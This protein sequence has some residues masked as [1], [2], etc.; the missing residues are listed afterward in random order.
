MQMFQ[1][2]NRTNGSQQRSSHIP[3]RIT[4]LAILGSLALAALSFA[5]LNNNVPHARA[6][7]WTQIWSD[8]FNGAAGTGLNNSNWLYDLGT[9]Y[10]GGAG[11]WGTGEVE[12]ETN[13][14][15]NVYQDGSGHLAIKPIRDANGNWTSGRVETQRT[16]FAAPAGGMIAFEASLQMPNVTGA[17]AQGY[18]PAFWMLGDSF[19]GNYTNWPMAGE[20]DGMENVNGTNMEYGTLHCGYMPG[21]PCNE[22]NGLGGHQPCA[23]TTCQAAFHTYRVEI[24][25]STSPEQIRWYLDGNQFWQVSANS[26]D[27]TTWTNAVDHGFFVILNVAMGGSW[28]GN[29]SGATASGVPMLIDYVRVFTSGGSGSTPTPV[30]SSTPGST[31]TPTPTPISNCPSGS[32]IQGADSTGAST[33][34][35]WFKPCDWTAGYVIIHY[36]PAG[37]GQQNVYM[38]YNAGTGHWEYPI[39]GLYTGQNLQ[40]SFTY[41]KQGLQYD[42]PWYSWTH[43]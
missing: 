17:Q 29:P 26:V 12:S 40:Y 31:P 33:A 32:F 22:T 39:G 23:P 19:R 11:N 16:N 37:Q 13:S 15:A 21:G 7:S 38:T 6:A 27:A 36:I 18:W 20:I 1:P 28:P 43:P 14:T 41:Q 25:R 4:V 5:S 10:P 9:S 24:D 34:T 2:K 8:E 42:T 35:P 3:L 30:P